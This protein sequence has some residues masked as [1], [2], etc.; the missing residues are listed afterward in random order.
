MTGHG[1]TDDGGTGHGEPDDG[2][3]AH[4]ETGHREPA[5]GGRRSQAERDAITVEI[6]YAL[7]SA[8]FAA[9]V[10]FGAI[11]GP[12]FLFDLPRTSEHVLR[13]GG[14]ILA[15]VLFFVRVASVLLRF[16]PGA[17]PSQPGRTRPDS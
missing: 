9:A 15:T 11:A 7:C 8:L 3:T 4:G 5:Y 2:G 6:G 12:A 1:G 10:V 16:R 13:L 17:Q 14:A